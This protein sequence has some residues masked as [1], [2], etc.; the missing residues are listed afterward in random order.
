M[1][2]TR[3]SFIVN[4][5]T[6]AF[7]II[8]DN[9][10]SSDAAEYRGHRFIGVFFDS[11]S[12]PEFFLVTSDDGVSLN[13]IERPD[14]KKFIGRDP[15]LIFFD[16]HWY[17]CHTGVNRGDFSSDKN[18]GDFTIL[19]SNDLS[20]WKEFR[21]PAF[22]HTNL[23]GMSGK[24]LDGNI[25]KIDSVW[26]PSFVT[27]NGELYTVISVANRIINTSG[28]FSREGFSSAIIKCTD[29]NS[30]QFSKPIVFLQ[31]INDSYIDTQIVKL[32]TGRFIAVTKSELSGDIIFFESDHL[33]NG[34]E[35]LS[36]LPFRKLYGFMVEAPNL[37]W[38]PV[39]SC[40]FVYLDRPTV[41]K[42]YYYCKSNDLI[43]WS[44]PYRVVCDFNIRHGNLINI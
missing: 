22:G 30:M 8:S 17:I 6:A 25:G 38:N 26:A 36:I 33:S 9:S 11:N 18:F 4:S 35:K 12:D 31:D 39:F 29:V 2:M 24:V 13:K 27:S 15:N 42:E 10:H 20:T 32:D 37:V 7:L 28:G 3:R 19:K 40:W 14:K 44:K 41:N 5:F 23:R 16:G 34:Y 43:N 21:I 1:K